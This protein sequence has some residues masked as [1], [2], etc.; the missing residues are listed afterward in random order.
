[1]ANFATLFTLGADSCY[2]F[3]MGVG[4]SGYLPIRFLRLELQQLGD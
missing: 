1:V 4:R 2:G 3:M